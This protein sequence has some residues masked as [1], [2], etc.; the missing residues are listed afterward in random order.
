MSLSLLLKKLIKT[1]AGRSRFILAI[2]GLSIA[3]F[4]I[5]S[6]VQIQANYDDLLHNKTNQDSIANFLVINKAV[7]SQNIG[8]TTLTEEQINDVKKQPFV[9][10]LGILTASRFKVSA[11]GATNRLPFYTDLFFESVPDAFLD[12]NN[13]DWEWNDQSTFIPIIIPNSFLDMYNFGF[14][15]SQGLPKLSQDLVK[16]I[17]LQINIQSPNGPVNYYAKVVGFSDRIASILVPQ[18]FM[19]WANNKF[20]TAP[21]ASPS[22]IVIRTKDPGSPELMNYLKDHGLTTDAD[23][24]RFSKY[25]QVVN[26]VV[27]I[28]GITG[29][30]M[31]LFALLIFTLFIQLTIASCKEEIA[32]LVTLGAAPKQLKTFLM[33][34]FF[35][36]NIIIV[37]VTLIVIA[38]LQVWVK[39][40]LSGEHIFVS[41]VISM[42]TVVSAAL[43]LFVLWIVNYF[44][45]RKY[46]NTH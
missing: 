15:S 17:P 40:W 30:V 9:E 46:I 16:N 14:A 5:L 10:S 32:L 35:P 7:T 34:Q 43:I 31:L 11:Q 44:T 22:R 23:K 4:L 12:V 18:S 36:S 8:Q 28:S 26:T 21:P 19:D 6:A 27:N 29:A 33:K 20:G 41:T 42:A 45:I 2:L 37:L 13:K 25:R 38:L 1:S 39:H 3:L 24:T